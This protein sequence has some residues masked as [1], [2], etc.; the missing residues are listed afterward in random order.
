MTLTEYRKKRRFKHSAEP[1]G[2]KPK[3]SKKLLYV[4][5]EHAASHL[6][7][8]FRIELNGVLKSWA[9]PKGPSLDPEVKR[10]AV[11][12]E[13]HPIEYGSFHGVIPKGNYGAGTVKIWDKGTWQ[14]QD[15][16]P[17]K[18]Y[19]NGNLTF[20]LKGKKLKGLWKLIQIKSDPKNWLFIK[21]HDK[22][23]TKTNSPLTKIKKP[24]PNFISPQLCTLVKEPPNSDDW[25][26]EIKFDGYRLMAFI[27][28][29][30]VKLL[31]RNKN[32][33]TKRFPVLKI[34]LAKLKLSTAIL[35]GE[36]VAINNN[37]Q[38]DFQLLQ[39]LIHK[40]DTSSLYY[41][42]FD[43]LYYNGYDLSQTPLIERK[44]ILQQLLAK[45]TNFH[46]RYSDHVIGNGIH[47]YRKS[48]QL[49]LEGIISKQIDSPY[50]PLRSHYWLKAK[51]IDRQ[52]F[53]VGGFTK[54]QGE[55]QHFGSLLIGINESSNKLTYCGHVG[56]G[57][58]EKTLKTISNL[59]KKY[60]STHMPFDSVPT[61]EAKNVCWVK[62]KLII[63]VEFRGWT[64]DKILRQASFK[65]I[66][67][68]KNTED[69]I[70]EKPLAIQNFN[71]TNPN[72]ILYP[73]QSITKT[74]IARYYTS[75]REWI[76]PYLVNRPLTLVRCPNGYQNQCFYQK[77]LDT[78]VKSIFPIVITGD[79]EPFLYIKNYQGLMELVQLGT[80]EIHPWGSRIDNI[81]RPDMMIFDLDPAPDVPWKKVIQAAYFV[82]EQLE[83]LN[84]ISFVKTTGGKGLHIYI[85]IKRQY[86]WEE[87]KIYSHTFVQYL[88][89][90]R[91]DHYVGIM[92]KEKRKGKIF[93][94]YLR[95]QRGATAIAP[96]CTRAKNGAPVST[97]LSWE[98]LSNKI[99]PDFYTVKN[100]PSRLSQLKNDP[101]EGFLSLKQVLKMK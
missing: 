94:D 91:P 31:T 92:T 71:L 23:T 80:L 70:L 18:A 42:I 100:V 39:N 29:K 19:K 32:D 89:S 11:H 52:E 10:L 53:I 8:D 9:I 14:S 38:F 4:I 73:E 88:V 78:D 51:C 3:S 62:P 77:H 101:W 41:Y 46:I 1:R 27:N 47:T 17:N 63:E 83:Q 69:I 87:L 75:I 13:D 86:S 49:G 2:N 34:E 21:I 5:Q 24:M 66:R 28:K 68:D 20:L 65:G 59:L 35:D 85:P 67:H 96:Y 15:D 56:T 43:I 36:L 7:Y 64:R 40:K 95:N 97:P 6:H 93:I 79:K 48:C 60:K 12:V 16:D 90:L 30:N 50:L 58:N 76:L 54:P 33:W 57:F 44:E 61:A 45:N 72:K 74:D 26:H 22:Y 98:E 55:R 82:R 84:L 81:E 25:L 37:G 99:K